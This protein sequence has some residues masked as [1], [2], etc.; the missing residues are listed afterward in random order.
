MKKS[1]VLILLIALTLFYVHNSFAMLGQVGRTATRTVGAGAVRGAT[2]GAATGIRLEPQAPGTIPSPIP[3]QSLLTP[4]EQYSPTAATHIPLT[5]EKGGTRLPFPA[6]GHKPPEAITIRKSDIEIKNEFNTAPELHKQGF[7]SGFISDKAVAD[8]IKDEP[9]AQELF[10][11]NTNEIK[12]AEGKIIFTSEITPFGGYRFALPKTNEQKPTV[13]TI[14]AGEKTHRNFIDDE[15]FQ[16]EQV[17]IKPKSAKSEL[18]DVK[19]LL[20]PALENTTVKKE[21]RRAEAEAQ[22]KAE[23]QEKELAA[24]RAILEKIEAEKKTKEALDLAQTKEAEARLLLE[25]LKAQEIAAQKAAEETAKKVAEKKTDVIPSEQTLSALAEQA[26]MLRAQEL[27]SQQRLAELDTKTVQLTENIEQAKGQLLQAK[28]KEDIEIEKVIEETLQ[29]HNKEA[30]E[31]INQYEQEQKELFEQE[32]RDFETIA[33]K[34][35][36]VE[37]NIQ[38][39]DVKIEQYEQQIAKLQQDHEK[40]LAEKAQANTEYKR[41]QAERDIQHQAQLLELAEEEK[42]DMLQ[43]KEASTQRQQQLEAEKEQRKLNYQEKEKDIE[44]KKAKLEKEQDEAKQLLEQ[45]KQEEIATLQ[46]RVEKE[47]AALEQTSALE[48][49]ELEQQRQKQIK[50]SETQL[51]QL[52]QEYS[53]QETE[54]ETL[55][56]KYQ[57]ALENQKQAKTEHEASLAQQKAENLELQKNEAEEGKQKLEQSINEQK[58]TLATLKNKQAQETRERETNYA[59]LIQQE[60]ELM[61]KEIEEQQHNITLRKK[62]HLVEIKTND[63]KELLKLEAE[64]VQEK[65]LSETQKLE[66]A[67]GKA[68][69]LEAK[70]QQEKK[71][72]AEIAAM[73]A[74][75][76]ALKQKRLDAL[77][78]QLQHER[79]AEDSIKNQLKETEQVLQKAEQEAAQKN[80]EKTAAIKELENEKQLLS[81]QLQTI[82]EEI[83]SIQTDFEI[84]KSSLKET[85][86]EIPQQKSAFEKASGSGEGDAEEKQKKKKLTIPEKEIHPAQASEAPFV[87]LP[88]PE[89]PAIE[90]TTASI[91]P[92]ELLQQ[93]R[94]KM[95]TSTTEQKIVQTPQSY[96]STSST[97]PPSL[98]SF[99]QTRK[100][101]TPVSTSSYTGASQGVNIVRPGFKPWK[102]EAPKEYKPSPYPMPTFRGARQEAVRTPSRQSPILSFDSSA[103]AVAEKPHIP[104][105][106]MK[107]ARTESPPPVKV[108]PAV[109]PKPAAK[110]EQ[111]IAKQP[112]FWQ[113]L[114]KKIWP[115]KTPVE[116]K[117]V[118]IETISWYKQVIH[119]IIDT[120]S[121]IVDSFRTVVEIITEAVYRLFH[122]L[123]NEPVIL[124][125]Q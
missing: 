73:E 79:I 7:E 6:A 18:N 69:E 97:Q 40:A 120:M 86:S 83:K 11:S 111:K 114:A 25:Q 55:T 99:T 13:Y 94:E 71:E 5:S 30:E 107:I 92:I 47:M 3:V 118:P 76:A 90:Q 74:E 80:T 121:I 32:T 9:A 22:Q 64:I 37:K 102:K 2:R 23:T 50:D 14:F 10:Q 41:Q 106:Q 59:K 89:I 112:T 103:R 19:K 52:Q 17:D 82:S 105:T 125:N 33:A 36:I 57:Q 67:Q 60:T 87:I 1:R 122:P 61:K 51:L 53:Q 104:Y 8:L 110:E 24:K 116:K 91:P 100:S 29:E 20:G 39:H 63:Q 68:Q 58:Q 88:L 85:T 96:T 31:I 123:E 35:A 54:I 78:Q 34:Q 38:E 15:H 115:Q 28:E 98:P 72:L 75:L 109:T 12:N 108:T 45:K 46:K 65:E 27:A 56:Q 95:Q 117:A 124:Y 119:I 113:P 21:L 44:E 81:E 4:Q 101:P 48:K 66:A 84:L 16:W 93:K 26:E 70:K 77:E 43:Q 62:Q 42:T 49:T